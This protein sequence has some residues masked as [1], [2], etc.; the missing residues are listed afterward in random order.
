MKII[1][2]LQLSVLHKSFT[3]LEKDIFA[4]SIPIAFSLIDG[5]ILLEQKLWEMI[6]EQMQGDVFD[7]AMPKNQGEVLVQGNFIALK[8]QPIEAGSVHLKLSSTDKKG[9]VQPKVDKDGAFVVV[10]HLI[11]VN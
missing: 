3:Y 9:I 6:S 4:V 2:P 5:E 7:A 1:K 11:R 10:R 8:E